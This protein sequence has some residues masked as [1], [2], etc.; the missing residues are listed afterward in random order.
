MSGGVVKV[1][2]EFAGDY[3][4]LEVQNSGYLNGHA[5][6]SDGFGLFS[7]RAGYVIYLVDKANS[8]IFTKWRT[9]NSKK[10]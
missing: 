2:S 1:S 8:S 9:G 7:T 10:Y 3:H 6:S 5:N 4:V